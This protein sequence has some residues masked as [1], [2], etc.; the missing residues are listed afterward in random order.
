MHPEYPAT[1]QSY[2]GFSWFCS[3]L[4]QIMSW[5]P[6]SK[7]HCLLIQF[8]LH[9]FQN[10]FTNAVV[11][12]CQTAIQQNSKFR[13]NDQLFLLLH[14]QTPKFQSP[15]RLT[16]QSSALHPACL[17]QQDGRAQRRNPLT[18]YRFLLCNKCSTAHC[19]PPLLSL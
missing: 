13:P 7:S 4:E 5:Y 2:Q 8:I 9:Y 11:P 16:S 1:G 17:Y 15:Y 18:N 6:T 14:T 10:F 3:V 12:I 19:I